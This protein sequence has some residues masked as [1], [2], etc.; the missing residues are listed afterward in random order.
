[1]ALDGKVHTLAGLSSVKAIL[2]PIEYG[3]RWTPELGI[4]PWSCS[5]RQAD[6][7]SLPPLQL[8]T[9]LTQEY[10]RKW[11]NLCHVSVLLSFRS[12]CGRD[13]SPKS[14][15]EDITELCKVR[16]EILSNLQVPVEKVPDSIFRYDIVAT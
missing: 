15:Q 3:T 13:P 8:N 16:D 9:M 5:C 11:V 6:D 14:R 2:V 12:R 10:T 7:P 4:E 1:L